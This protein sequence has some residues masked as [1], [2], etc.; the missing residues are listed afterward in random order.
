MA[1]LDPLTG[2]YARKFWEQMAMREIRTAF[3]FKHP[4]TLAVLDL[5]KFKQINDEH[6][7]LTGDKALETVGRVLRNSS[8]SSDVVG[9]FGGDEFVVL[10][11]RT[12][13][14]GAGVFCNRLLR[15]LERQELS[16]ST[17]ICQIHASIGLST[18]APH[19][20]DMATLPR[21]IP[22]TFFQNTLRWLFSRADRQVYISKRSGGNCFK[23]SDQSTWPDPK[24]SVETQEP[25]N[26]STLITR[27][28]P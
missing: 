5:D 10:L 1:T 12:S 23:V 2:V 27:E 19:E 21:P 20:F 17:G 15:E 25:S 14:D 8:R 26:H 22:S 9:R 3:R 24:D 7:H 4:I 28:E 13:H 6:G 18:L 11:P 16:V